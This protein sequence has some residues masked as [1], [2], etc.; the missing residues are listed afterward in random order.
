MKTGMK[1]IMRV[2]LTAPAGI[3][4][5]EVLRLSSGES[6]VVPVVWWQRFLARL[7]RSDAQDDRNA[8]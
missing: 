5:D 7:E 4:T 2:R 1:K 8:A 6:L 3:G